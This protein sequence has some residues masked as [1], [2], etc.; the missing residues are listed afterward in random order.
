MNVGLIL[1][2]NI[3]L[4]LG[5]IN[6]LKLPLTHFADPI[7]LFAV[8]GLLPVHFSKKPQAPSWAP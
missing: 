7:Y 2:K 4:I 3:L 1:V 6:G 5:D 8:T